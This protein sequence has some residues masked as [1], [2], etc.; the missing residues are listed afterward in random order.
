[1]SGFD[2]SEDSVSVKNSN[3]GSDLVKS[4]SNNSIDLNSMPDELDDSL[5]LSGGAKQNIDLTSI[6]I[7]GSKNWFTNRL[8]NREPDVFVLSKE[9]QKNKNY[10]KYT[11]GCPWQFKKQPIIL[12]D[13]ELNK[14]KKADKK[15]KSKSFDGLVKYRGY[16]YICP[17]YWCFKDNNGESRSISFQQINEGE[18][19]GWDAVNPKKSK[20]LLPGKRIIELTD[21]RMHNPSKS[22]NP[23]VYKP[24]FPFLQKSENHPKGMCAPCCSQVPLDNEGF[25][26]ESEEVRKERKKEQEMYFKD[27][28]KVI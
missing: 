8:R 2:S 9:D 3:N 20:S 25:P 1:M 4:N 10:V 19:G 28:G 21:N 11:K 22:N 24:L 27:L 23:M 7:Q 26:N 18:C 14:I 6:K 5:S 13:D 17:R 16:N 12:N 15:S